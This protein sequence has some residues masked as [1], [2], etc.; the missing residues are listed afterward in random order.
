[1]LGFERPEGL[2]KGRRSTSALI[3]TRVEKLE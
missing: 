3:K 2:I 1:M